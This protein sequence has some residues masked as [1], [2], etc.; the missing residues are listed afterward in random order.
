MDA[1]LWVILG[2][3][4][5]ALIAVVAIASMRRRRTR[6]LQD[7]FGPEYD[8]TIERQGDQRAAESELAARSDR[9]HA[10]DIRPLGPEGR[11]RHARSWQQIQ[12]RF[13]D[14]PQAAVADADQAIT[15]VMAERGYPVEDFDRRAAD[16]SV[17]HPVVV[18]NY[19]AAHAISQRSAAGDATTEHLR[20][21]MVHYRALFAELVGTEERD[22]TG[23]QA[24]GTVRS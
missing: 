16:V 2:V 10:L 8:R 11:E 21:A 6:Q 18:E 5:L 17:D 15:E 1:I 22:E 13:V 3:A 7:R 14:E 4:L 9:R 19:R 20:Q 12:R 24:R 23:P